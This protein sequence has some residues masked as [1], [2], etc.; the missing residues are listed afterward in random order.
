MGGG[1]LRKSRKWKNSVDDYTHHHV[2]IVVLLG[3]SGGI[4]P[5]LEEAHTVTRL[6]CLASIYLYIKYRDSEN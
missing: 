1:Y 2:H 5:D 6:N 4:P 3:K